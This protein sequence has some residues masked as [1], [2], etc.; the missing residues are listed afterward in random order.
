MSHYEERLERDL[1]QIRDRV[2][3]LSNRAYEALDNAIQALRTGNDKLAYMTILGDGRIN[4]AHREL[5]QQCYRFIAL[6]LPSAGHLRLISSIIRTNIQL[7]RLGDYAVTIAREAVQL[8]KRP[9]GMVARELE[10][11]STDALRML[12]Q[13]M[14]A[15]N[16]A[17]ESMARATMTM[18]SHVETTLDS[19]YSDLMAEGDRTKVKDLLAIFVVFNM[20][21][22]I[23]DQAKNICE[24]TIFA[25]TG[26]LKP[27]AV[28]DILFLDE[29]NAALSPMAEAIA[30]KLYPDTGHYTSAGRRAAGQF[31]PVMLRFAKQKGFELSASKPQAF[32]PD[33]GV[34]RYFVVVS[35]AGPVNSYVGEIPFHTS[36]LEWD[37]GR[38]PVGVSDEE[39]LTAYEERYRK[40]VTHM[41]DLVEALRGHEEG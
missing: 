39:A 40:I 34:A 9:D 19:V 7:E 2:M 8:S 23:M 31:D 1:S 10:L 13:S 21:K 4:R 25:T 41:R 3:K 38:P 17:S 26:Q 15:F 6:H 16:E 11:I 35:L 12:E 22:R 30:R 29:D 24:E 18:A 28:Y 27:Q 37:V 36:A 20:I 32:D 5:D 14:N 33:Q